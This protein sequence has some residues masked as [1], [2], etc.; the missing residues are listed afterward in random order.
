[1]SI[2]SITTFSIDSSTTFKESARRLSPVAWSRETTMLPPSPTQINHSGDLQIALLLH[3][4]FGAAPH[5]GTL[6][7]LS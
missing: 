6:P 7:E 4:T 1:M 5:G 3:S 2:D